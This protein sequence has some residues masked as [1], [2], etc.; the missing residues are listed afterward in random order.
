MDRRDSEKKHK[1]THYIFPQA[2]YRHRNA[3][4][5]GRRPQR[6]SQPVSPR[7]TT[8][9]CSASSEK[10]PTHPDRKNRLQ[11][12]GTGVPALGRPSSVATA[13][14]RLTGASAPMT[15]T[16]TST[17]CGPD[18]GANDA[19]PV[20]LYSTRRENGGG[21]TSPRHPPARGLPTDAPKV[22]AHAQ[23]AGGAP[24]VHGAFPSSR[25]RHNFTASPPQARPG[26]G[27]SRFS[28]YAAAPR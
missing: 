9:S 24:I 22:P 15:S 10:G 11:G 14:P 8:S 26:R 16:S 2:C 13:G 3:D 25:E 17:A 27:L 19:N 5:S 6:R 21:R 18:C 28:L 23:P 1:E 20:E 7:P 4:G 12:M